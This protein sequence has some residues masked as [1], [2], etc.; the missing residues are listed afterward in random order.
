VDLVIAQVATD[1]ESYVY[2]IPYA[3]DPVHLLT[4]PGN[5]TAQLRE[6]ILGAVQQSAAEDVLTAGISQ[7]GDDVLVT[8]RSY[9]SY[10][11]LFAALNRGEILAAAVP[12]SRLDR[13]IGGG[14]TV[15]GFTPGSISYRAATTAD[16]EAL[17]QL[18]GVILSDWEAEGTLQTLYETYGLQ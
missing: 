17:T 4:L 10:P 1:S 11:D 15:H 8:C 2:S 6:C 12:A 18:V 14:W 13:Y 16:N 3:K 9:P 7:L 5:E